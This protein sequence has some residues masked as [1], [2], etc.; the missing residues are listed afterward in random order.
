[1]QFTNLNAYKKYQVHKLLLL[2]FPETVYH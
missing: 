2:P 1:M